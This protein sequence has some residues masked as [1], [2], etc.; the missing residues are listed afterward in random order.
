MALLAPAVQSLLREP[1][2]IVGDNQPRE[3]VPPRHLNLDAPRV[4]V[5][6]DVSQRLL[7]R[8]EQQRLTRVGDPEVAL[9][10]QAGRKAL[11]LE[12]CEHVPKGGLEPCLVEA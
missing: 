8:A 11:S 10:R 2:T 4:G 3:P 6:S 5:Q 9:D 1:P 12:R 7:G